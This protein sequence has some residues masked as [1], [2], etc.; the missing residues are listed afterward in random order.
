MS[1]LSILYS[2][3]GQVVLSQQGSNYAINTEGE[4][5]SLKIEYGEKRTKR[6]TAG[7]GYLKSTIDDQIVKVTTTPFDS[8]ALLPALFPPYLGIG[9][10]GALTTSGKLLIG[11]RPHDFAGG[12][13]GASV[14]NAT[15]QTTVYGLDGR[16]FT[17]A[18]TAITK[19]PNIKLGVGMPLF[20]G[21]EITG[22]VPVANA[23]GPSSGLIAVSNDPQN[24]GGSAGTNN[25]VSGTTPSYG[26]PDFVNGHWTGALGSLTGFTALDAEDGWDITVDAKYSPLTVQKRTCHYKLDGVEIVCKARLTG[27]SQTQINAQVLAHTLGGVLTGTPDNLV[28]N[29]PSGKSITLYDVEVFMEGSG[30]EFGGNKLSNG[31]T[32]FVS[33]ID[34]TAGVPNL[35]MVFSS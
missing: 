20:G 19:H 15:A 21:I 24:S 13:L 14:I 7:F 28:L 22:L 17:I 16:L 10:A 31:E 30:F 3:P 32:A 11:T 25:F 2:G 18:R 33:N 8:W 9:T 23:I 27:P 29:G 34:F 5:G 26:V 6:S 12:T 1:A 35:A 4:N